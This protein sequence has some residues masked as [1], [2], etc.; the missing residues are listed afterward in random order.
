MGL[1][2]CNSETVRF[3]SLLAYKEEYKKFE[4]SIWPHYVYYEIGVKR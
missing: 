4:E 3:S 1:S 2:D